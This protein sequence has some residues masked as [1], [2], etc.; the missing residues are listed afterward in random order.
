[1]LKRKSLMESISSNLHNF[2]KKISNNLSVPDKK[3]LRDG[4]IGLLRCGAARSLS[5]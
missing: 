3:F 1:M 2:L 4:F 5:H